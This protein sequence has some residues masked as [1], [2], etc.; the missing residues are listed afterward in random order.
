MS[1]KVKTKAEVLEDQINAVVERIR[2]RFTGTNPRAAGTISSNIE[3]ARRFFRWLG[4]V[5]F[6]RSD[7]DRYCA[8]RRSAEIKAST[9]R[10]EFFNIQNLASVQGIKLELTKFDI[11]QIPKGEESVPHPP[12]LPEQ[13]EQLIAAQDKYSDE[14]RYYLSI[15]TT[16]ACRR[17]ALALNRKRDVD[18]EGGTIY[19]RVVHKG[20]AVRHLIPEVLKPIITTYH[21]KEREDTTMSRI[22][23]R[24][25]IKAG[26]KLER[27]YGW[28]SIRE[29]IGSMVEHFL[30]DVE[31]PA[32]VAHLFKPGAKVPLSI[33]SDYA[34]WTK[35]EKGR[36]FLGSAMAGHYSHSEI[37]GKDP[38]WIDRAIYPVHPFLKCWEKALGKKRKNT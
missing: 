6:A 16:F 30:H 29:C 8:Y 5:K 34:G 22:F 1:T 9:I 7:I 25:T 38:Y 26:L 33:W 15:S 17:H 23:N 21:A 18:V 14:E 10:K 27:G 13:V 19:I 37:I 3:T 28:H 12:L 35:E 11:P 24:I 32:T 4:R 2:E 36:V 20:N 31:Y